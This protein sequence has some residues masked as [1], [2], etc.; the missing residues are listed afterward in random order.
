MADL[1]IGHSYFMKK[2]EADFI[3][4]M[5]NGISC[6]LWIRSSGQSNHFK[7]VGRIE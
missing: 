1:L 5:N 3:K 2:T 4:I 6:L 7:A